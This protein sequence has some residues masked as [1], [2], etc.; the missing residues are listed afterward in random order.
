MRTKKQLLN[1]G[2]LCAGMFLGGVLAGLAIANWS[3][4]ARRQNIDIT[5]GRTV[6]IT[7]SAIIDGSDRFIFAPDT[8]YNEHSRWKPP[9]NVLFNGQPWEDLSQPPAGWPELARNL[10]LSKAKIVAR[11]GRDVIALVPAPEGFDLYFADT[12]MGSGAYEV[13]ISIPQK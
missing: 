10:D 13:T 1:L 6:S 2:F 3:H 8:A 5:P 7:L 11:K 4:S 12:P 9:Q